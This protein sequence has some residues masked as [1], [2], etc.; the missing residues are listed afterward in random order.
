[1][2]M[3]HGSWFMVHGSWFMAHGSWLMVHGSWLIDRVII[4]QTVLSSV[5]Y[6]GGGMASLV[7]VARKYIALLR[8]RIREE[9][10][11]EK[12]RQ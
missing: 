4:S 9:E 3:A 2:A 5:L 6:R 10:K 11:D 1:M 12:R 8:G 7:V